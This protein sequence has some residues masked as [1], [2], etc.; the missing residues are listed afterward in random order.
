MNYNDF[1]VG[2]VIEA[3]PHFVEE[4]AI[5]EFA[6]RFDPQPFHINK[7]VAE[8]SGWNGLIAS[9]WHT[10][11]I[12]MRL[13]V[14]TIL[15]GSRSCGSPGLEYLKWPAPVRAGDA[16]TLK[17]RVLEVRASRSGHY[18]IVRWQ[19]HLAN[20]R[21]QLVLDLVATSLFEV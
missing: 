18:G 16:L 12:A 2:Q 6:S 9:G 13:V 20:Q 17:V 1:H 19:W 15:C 11:S 21:D 14:D 10:C 8:E 3:G 4:S 5:V 7:V